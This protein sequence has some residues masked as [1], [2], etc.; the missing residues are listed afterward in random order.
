MKILVLEDPSFSRAMLDRLAQDGHEL[1]KVATAEEAMAL[2]LQEK[3]E[4]IVWVQGALRDAL[5]GLPNRVA[6]DEALDAELG[7]ALRDCHP[8]ALIL[9]AV[10]RFSSLSKSVGEKCLTDVAKALYYALSRPGDLVARIGDDRFAIILPSTHI[11]GALIVAEGLKSKIAGLGATMSLGVCAIDARQ[12][13]SAEAF[14]A[15][16]D[17]ALYLAQSGGGNRVAEAGFDGLTTRS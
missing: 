9:A 6:F 13:L 3:G 4:A 14:V 7:R 8:L 10:D 1:I 17:K 11:A 5:T 2:A 12:G 16:A 15:A